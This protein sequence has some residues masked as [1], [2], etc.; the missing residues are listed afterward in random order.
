MSGMIDS[1]LFRARAL[2]KQGDDEAAKRAYLD[3]LRI[4]PVH[5]GALTEF[6]AL[7]H[8]SGHLSAAREAYRQAVRFHPGNSVAHVGYAYLLS[9]AGDAV[10]A[11][12]HYQAALATDPDLPEAHQGLARVLTDLGENADEHWRKGF[13][14]RA[15]VWRRYRGTGSGIPLQLLVAAVGGNIPTQH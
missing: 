15:V 10:E 7:A 11:R 9:E 8:A 2:L 14:G 5:C 3:V 4:D 1:A 12:S 13:N 6:G